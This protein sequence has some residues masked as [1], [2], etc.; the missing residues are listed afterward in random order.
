MTFENKF[1]VIDIK[2]EAPDAIK[3]E[4]INMGVS[5][6]VSNVVSDTTGG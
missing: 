2:N 3:Y 4:L 1:K 5:T 6:N